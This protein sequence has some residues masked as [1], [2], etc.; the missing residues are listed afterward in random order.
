MTALTRMEANTTK[1]RLPLGA[2]FLH[3]H[4]DSGRIVEVSFSMQG[5]DSNPEIE[6]ILTPIF[7][8]ITQEIQEISQRW[9]GA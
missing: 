2:L 4:H 7:E 1:L 8:G 5:R 6:A 3:V 9:G